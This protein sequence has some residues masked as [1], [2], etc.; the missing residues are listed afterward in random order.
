M[1]LTMAHAYY[2]WNYRVSE[3]CP[4]LNIPEERNVSEFELAPVIEIKSFQR[5]QLSGCF[6]IFSREDVKRSDAESLYSLE[7]IDDGQGPETQ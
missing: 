3:P 6:P 5:T 4:S 1:I 7:I 2:R